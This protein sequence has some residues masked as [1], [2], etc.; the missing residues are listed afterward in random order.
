MTR[1]VK[2]PAWGLGDG[3][4]I[5][6]CCKDNK[7][8]VIQLEQQLGKL[9]KGQES[10]PELSSGRRKRGTPEAGFDNS[11]GKENAKAF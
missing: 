8:K 4:Q 6:W 11:K 3:T 10:D 1:K 9:G 2:R 7:G 5:G